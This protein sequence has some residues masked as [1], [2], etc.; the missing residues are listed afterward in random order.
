MK[1]EEFKDEIDVTDVSNEILATSQ[2]KKTIVY[3]LH[4]MLNQF[5]LHLDSITN[6][7]K[8]MAITLLL[9]TYAAIGFTFSA[10]LSQLELNKWLLVS[11]IS[12]F[13]MIGIMSIWHLDIY[14]FH[15]FWGAFF[16]EEVRMEKMHPFLIK[17]GDIAVSLNDVKSRI[18]GHGNFYV[19]AMILLMVTLGVGVSFLTKNFAEKIGIY[20]A[21]ALLLLACLFF[22]LKA[23][24]EFEKILENFIISAQ[25]QN[26]SRDEK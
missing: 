20:V 1:I 26:A 4:S 6:R 14:V 19:F 11:L 8:A 13:G 21:A 12:F 24:H 23:T 17:I 9:G 22:M 3:G 10:K 7:Y 2:S 16:V 25:N 18:T 15:K 5:E